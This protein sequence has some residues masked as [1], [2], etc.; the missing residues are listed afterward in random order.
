MTT[1]D[2][3]H[4]FHIGRCHWIATKNNKIES[5][6]ESLL[7]T[8]D[9]NDVIAAYKFENALW[10]YNWLGYA[11]PPLVVISLYL[12]ILLLKSKVIQL[13]CLYAIMLHFLIKNYCVCSFLAYCC[14]HFIFTTLYVKEV[15]SALDDSR[16]WLI[17]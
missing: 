4:L 12:I 13:F 3:D 16:I 9:I 8:P 1:I 7:D 14:S 10:V 11:L 15:T 17:L 5:K 6:L 2:F